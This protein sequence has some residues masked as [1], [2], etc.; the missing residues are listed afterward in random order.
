[1]QP[2]KRLQV[3]NLFTNPKPPLLQTA[4]PSHSVLHSYT[5]DHLVIK[6]SIHDLLQAP[7]MNWQYNRPA[8]P[9]RCEEI[10]RY[11]YRSKKP[12]DTM[13]YLSLNQKTNQ[14]DVIDGIHRYTALTNIKKQTEELDLI[15]NE[16]GTDPCEWL[17]DSYMILNIR[18]NATDGE[19]VE[20]FQS[21]N[22]SNPIPELYVRDVKKDKKD[23]VESVCHKWQSM[24][25][26]HFSASNKP[27]K[28]NINRDRFIDILDAV[29]DKLH[30]TEETKSKLEQALQRTNVHISQN[31]PAKLTKSIKE[32]CELTGCWL[33][34]YTSDE[35]VKML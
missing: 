3:A 16:F 35:L 33:F 7:I 32:K 24:Y 6:V 2:R 11:I 1:M 4:F 22:K 30:L 15:T 10:S 17:F 31:L 28:P 18:L 26:T 23:C 21:L 8:D 19:L 25:K 5:P 9:E 12:V 34:I 14:F 29:Y 27:Q 20:L 13:L